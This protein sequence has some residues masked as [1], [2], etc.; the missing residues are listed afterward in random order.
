LLIHLA[1]VV[2]GKVRV[3][4]FNVTDQ[5]YPIMLYRIHLAMSGIRT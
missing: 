3:M 2:L 5:F 4:V 1:D